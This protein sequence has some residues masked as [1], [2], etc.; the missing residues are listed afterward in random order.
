M[1]SSAAS[2]SAAVAAQLART[3]SLKEDYRFNALHKRCFGMG[4]ID[5]NHLRTFAAVIELGSF[6]AAA[7]RFNVTQ[8]AV[9]LQVKLL[10]RRLGVRLVERVGRRAHPTAAGRDL[11][12]H[13]RGIDEAV[14]R[15]VEA[16]AAHRA[17]DGA[18]RVRL[19]TGAT[20]CIYVLPPI[21]RVLRSRLPSLEIVVRTGNTPDIIR[22]LEE[23]AIDVALVTLP[24]PGRMFQVTPSLE[25]ELVAIFPTGIGGVGSGGNPPPSPAASPVT[26]ALLAERPLVL[27]EPGGHARRIIDD[28]FMQAGLS[29]KPIMELG[30]VEA[31]KELV[32]AGLGCAVLPRLA[33][34]GSGARDDLQVR[35]LSPRLHRR[36]GIVLRRDKPLDRDLRELVKAL[37]AAAGRVSV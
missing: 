15:A 16:M 34:T 17:G 11:L 24:A 37:E 1:D 23:N 18:G 8:P 3:R 25:D 20:A 9:S 7:V 32:G 14:S 12:Q 30:S 35:P 33:V 31:I 4:G 2:N 36:L 26:A 13:A 19:G 5:L 28:W 27:Y 21:L 22:A 10:E 29:P 6:S